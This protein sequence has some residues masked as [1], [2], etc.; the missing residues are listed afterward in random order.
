MLDLIAFDADDTL[1]Q[2]E[3][4][5]A[6]AQEKF[7]GLLAPYG[8][9]QTI[10]DRLSETET[11]NLE[12]YGYG[13]KAF[14]LSMLE[15]ALQVSAGRIPGRDL[16]VILGLGR[17]ML[18]ADVRLLD[19]AAPTVAALSASHVLMM[20]T[21]GDLRDQ[22]SKVARSGLGRYFK[23]IEVV[24]DKTRDSYAA[25]LAKYRVT[26]SRFLMVGNSLRSDVLP[27][28]AL[29]G[30]AVYIPY[31][32]TWEHENISSGSAEQGAYFELEHIGL[33]P[34]LVESLSLKPG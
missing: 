31:H 21:K 27:V 17:E 13:I 2:N 23:Y 5:Y 8:D 26:A 24:S 33:L 22:E 30:L 18:T 32:I 4:L 10:A 14:T 12:H 19:H 11:R 6:S 25:I 9:A 34:A 15:T 7:A 29:G 16:Q 20:I 28:V 1:W 3:D